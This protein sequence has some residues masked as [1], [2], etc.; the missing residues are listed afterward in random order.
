MSPILKPRQLSQ[1]AMLERYLSRHDELLKASSAQYQVAYGNAL[2]RVEF[3]DRVVAA[4]LQAERQFSLELPPGSGKSIVAARIALA[5]IDRGPALYLS[6]SLTSVGDLSTGVINKF[7]RV[8]AEAGRSDLLLGEANDLS[9]AH[10]V[11]FATP[12]V[13]VDAYRSDHTRV[14]RLLERCSTFI[15]DEA[16]HFPSEGDLK[17]FGAIYEMTKH[18]PG[19]TLAMTGTWTRLDGNEVMGTR[20]PDHRITV[21]D[22]VDAGRCPEIYGIQIVTDVCATSARACGDL[23]DVHLKPGERRKYLR[24]IVDC[25]LKIYRRYPVPFAVFVRTKT[26]AARVVEDFCARSGLNLALLTS[27]V[28]Q[29]ARRTVIQ[30]IE[31]GTC[32]GYVTC[33]VGE[34]ALDLPKLE[35]V[36]LVRRTR[37]TARN[38]QAIGR[39]LRVC[40]GKRRALIVDYQTMIEGIVDR[41]IGLTLED[42]ARGMDGHIGRFVNGGPLVCQ[43]SYQIARL[44]SITMGEELELLRKDRSPIKQRKAHLLDLARSGAAKPK[45]KGAAKNNGKDRALAHAL[46]NYTTPSQPSFDAAFNTTIRSLR[47]DWFAQAHSSEANKTELLRRARVGLSAPTRDPKIKGEEHKLAIALYNYC[48]PKSPVYDPEFKT[49]IERVA[50]CWLK[51]QRRRSAELRKDFLRRARVEKQ[52]PTGRDGYLLRTYIQND[53]KFAAMI[54]ARAPSWTSN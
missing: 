39:A 5:R 7:A 35:V 3:Q 32:I 51:P 8:F 46:Y 38:M 9:L 47:P 27:D 2:A 24:G 31:N 16:H 1:V 49:E 44:V 30:S 43:R 12:R 26:D 19:L 14:T 10:D 11:V 37:S 36:H 50:P 4:A 15:V 34:E 29:A 28:S 17:I 54:A 6:P 23:Y 22:V 42:V 52:F 53:P 20:R 41:F 13:L 45:G 40:K 21:Q 48:Y 33:A 18:C 25:L